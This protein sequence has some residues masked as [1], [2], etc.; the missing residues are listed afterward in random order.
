MCIYLRG[1]YGISN[2]SVFMANL[3]MYLLKTVSVSISI[4]CH[5]ALPYGDERHI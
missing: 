3:Y 1:V 4:L 2:P 5:I